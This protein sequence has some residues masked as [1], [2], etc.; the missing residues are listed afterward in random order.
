FVP[1]VLTWPGRGISVRQDTSFPDAATTRLTITG[2]GRVDLRLRVPAGAEGAR[3]LVNGVVEGR[4]AAGTY[5]RV[6]RHWVS[7]DIV[8]LNLQPCERAHKGNF[9]DETIRLDHRIGEVLTRT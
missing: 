8:D 1:S 3:L 2:S 4:P 5:A 9:P 6:D 7:G